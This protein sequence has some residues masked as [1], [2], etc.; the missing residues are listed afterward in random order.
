M[1]N[2]KRWLFAAPYYIS[3]TLMAY[4]P[5]HIFLAQSLSL[6]TGGLDAWKIAKDLLAII[7]VL[8]VICSVYLARRAT[9]LFTCFVGLLLGYGALH[10]MVW[11]ANS[12]I[13]RDSALLGSV[14]N[15]RLPGFLLLGYGA[16][17]LLPKP[18]IW[19]PVIRIVL[20]ASTLVA[21][22]GLL[23]LLL[24]SDVL[25]HVGYSIERGARAT[26]FIDDK[27]GLLR[28]MSTLREPNALG[29]YLLMPA[30]LLLWL[31]TQQY[32]KRT[33]LFMGGALALH[34]MAI[35]FTF[36]R[37]AW[38]GLLLI[39]TTLLLWRYRTRSLALIRRFWIVGV[40]VLLLLAGGLYVARDHHL[41][42]RY[43]THGSDDADLDS[44]DYHWLFFKQGVEGIVDQPLGHGPGTAGLASIQNPSGSFLTE[45]YYVQIG[46]EVGILGLLVFIVLNAIVYA[47]LWKRRQH[48]VA[49][50]LLASFWAYV[51]I[52]MVLHIWS[53]EAV[54]CQWWL[55][56]GLALGWPIAGAKDEH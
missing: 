20:G 9:R 53:N 46:Y 42:E 7:A 30:S 39:A 15:L 11:A 13:Y 14:Y 16:T 54:A 34:G 43:I 4:M 40:A 50:A 8:F 56:A 45:N 28:I 55:L 44:N 27:E 49:M 23:Q 51:M 31:L 32:S 19:R 24:P 10:A 18:L 35:V 25:S 12:D 52:N 5:F 41:V 37:S 29:A 48:S 36:S 21:C 3:L 2:T 17:L 33:K 22:L 26:F 47:E 38:G 6:A 1:Q